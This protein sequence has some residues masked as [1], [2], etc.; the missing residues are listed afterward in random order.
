MYTSNTLQA[1]FYNT[2]CTHIRGMHGDHRPLWPSVN[3]LNIKKLNVHNIGI[4][5]TL[6]FSMYFNDHIDGKIQC[7]GIGFRSNVSIQYIQKYNCGTDVHIYF[8]LHCKRWGLHWQPKI[9]TTES[10]NISFPHRS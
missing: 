10:S 5:A 4:F 8:T 1:K 7:R 6:T 3:I 9:Q 2:F